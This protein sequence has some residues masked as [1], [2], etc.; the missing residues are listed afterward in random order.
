MAAAA[1]DSAAPPVDEPPPTTEAWH[2]NE[3]LA[4]QLQSQWEWVGG[5]VAKFQV[6]HINEGKDLTATIRS[7]LSDARSVRPAH[8]ASNQWGWRSAQ[9]CGGRARG[10]APGEPRPARTN[11]ETGPTRK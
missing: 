5:A 2:P 11:R 4:A 9:S 1:N 7:A 6:Q 10:A 3:K 8:A